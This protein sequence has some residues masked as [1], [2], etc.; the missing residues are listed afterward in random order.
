MTSVTA[1]VAM[2]NAYRNAVY[3]MGTELLCS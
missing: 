3:A 1:A 2:G